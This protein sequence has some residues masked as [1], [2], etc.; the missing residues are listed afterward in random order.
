MKILLGMIGLNEFNP[1]EIC[2]KTHGK[3]VQDMTWLKFKGETL[4]YKE[5]TRRRDA[6]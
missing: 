2:K 6:S 3:M 5:L 1:Y 4:T